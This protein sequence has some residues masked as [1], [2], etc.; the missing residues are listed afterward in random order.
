MASIYLSRRE[1]EEGDLPDVCMRCGAPATESKRRRFTSHPLWVY[2]L[3]PFGYLPYVIVAAVLTEKIRCCTLF[4]PRH[5]N[6]WRVR[7]LIIWGSFVAIPVLIFGGFILVAMLSGQLSEATQDK[8]FGLV[9]MGAALLAFCWLLSIPLIQ[10][11]AIHPSNGT[12]R[13]LTLKRVSPAFVDAVEE[14]R[15]NRKSR[16]EPEENRRTNRPHNN[17]DRIRRSPRHE[18]L[19]R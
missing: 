12:E 15:E 6:H 13:G 3:L 19:E 11:T 1:A 9:C 10:E 8:L 14:Y 16:R 17:E 18:D 4:C 5:K 7:T 2:V